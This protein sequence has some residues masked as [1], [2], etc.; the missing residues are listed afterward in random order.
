[1]S[2]DTVKPGAPT[3]KAV[4]EKSDRVTSQELGVPG[5]VVLAAK[6]LDHVILRLNKLLASPGG[7]SSFLSTLN[8]GL[9][10]LAYL[11]TQ[12]PSTTKLARTLLSLVNSRQHPAKPGTTTLA[13]PDGAVPPITALAQLV[14]RART[15][16]R[17][18]GLFPLY[19]WLR[20]LLADR[21]ADTDPV[22]H[23]IALLQCLSYIAYQALENISVLADN[24]IL[25]KNFVALIN[26]GD[27]TTARIYRLGYTAWLGGISCDFLRLAREAQLE[28]RRRVV[29]KRMQEE[30]K[31]VAEGQ[32]E[33][34]MRTDAK[35]WT[36]LMICSAWFPI[37]WQFSSTKGIPG[38]NSGWMGLCG[39]VAGSSRVQALWGA[40]LHP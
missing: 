10:V 14:S 22:L 11:Q 6:Q 1:M 32:E 2:D 36:D 17:L 29:R 35:W 38:W 40:T 9:Y 28:S 33:L 8:Y 24:G 39:L 4:D 16:L 13:T 18:F 5:T 19:A 23:R 12:S 21:K 26:R 15:T 34:D 20:T 25:S 3:A 37:A 27:P 7:L 31:A 30:G